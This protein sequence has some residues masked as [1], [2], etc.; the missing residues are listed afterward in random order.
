M[1]QPRQITH[2]IPYARQW[3]QAED[4]AAVVAVLNGNWLTTGPAVAGFERQLLACT[5]AGQAVALNSGTAALHAAYHA[6]GL[7]AGDEII[8]S[9]LTFA[10]TANAALYL[11]C[12][13][14]FVDVDPRTGLIDPAAIEAAI[15]EKT[16]AIVAVDYAGHPAD[17]HAIDAIARRHDL[18]VIA[19]GAHSLGAQ[20]RG[21]AVGTLAD[22]TTLSF[23]PVKPITSGEGGAVLTDDPRWARRARRFRNHGVT[24]DRDEMDG[25]EGP[26]DYEMR[27]LGYNYRLTDLQCALG[28]S[29]LKRLSQFIDR[30][31]EIASHYLD[32][33]SS[34]PQLE[35]PVVDDGVAPGW[36]L[37]VVRVRTDPR[38][39][40]PF[41]ERLRALKLGVQVHYRPVYLHPYYRELGYDEGL[42][43]KAEEFY[44]RALSLPLFPAMSDAEVSAVIRR[45]RRAAKDVLA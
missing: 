43:P 15:G 14:R 4:V 37:F 12:T 45:V 44:R 33:L 5:G 2:F 11:G 39:R 32:A 7:G 16:R 10:A 20:Y 3:L 19:D 22:L 18:R 30:R 24:R 21:R 31:R 29:Q 34:I 17:Y 38:L 41:F 8:T 26:W 28:Q 40:R 1:N 25:D 35:M 6:A 27:E 36:H 42:C 9:P 23:H 13:V